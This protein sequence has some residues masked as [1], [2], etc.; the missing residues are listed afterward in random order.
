MTIF[1]RPLGGAS[2]KNA[3]ESSRDTVDRGDP[4]TFN[5][6]RYLLFRAAG[7]GPEA[8]KKATINN[9]IAA[10]RPGV[11]TPKRIFANDGLVR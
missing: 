8:P 3:I 1:V 2:F 7:G 4:L 6:R 9:P 5:L 11:R 10:I